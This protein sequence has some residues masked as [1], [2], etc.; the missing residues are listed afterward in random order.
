MLK[1]RRGNSFDFLLQISVKNLLRVT[2]FQP[3]QQLEKK[4]TNI[5]DVQQIAAVLHV[6]LQISF[7]I[8][9]DQGQ[10]RLVEDDVVQIDDV[11]VP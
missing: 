9:K 1:K 6:T 4:Q 7:D 3:T 11:V 2:V 10:G 8:L 5:F